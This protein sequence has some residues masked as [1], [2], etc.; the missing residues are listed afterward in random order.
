[1]VVPAH[2]MLTASLCKKG[3][4]RSSARSYGAM[5]RRF[6]RRTHATQG[7]AYSPARGNFTTPVPQSTVTVVSR[8]PPCRPAVRRKEVL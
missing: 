8:P 3:V 4:T 6:R 5:R 1:M 2:C 7:E